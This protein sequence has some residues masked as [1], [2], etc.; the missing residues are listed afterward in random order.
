[1]ADKQIH[2]AASNILSNKVSAILILGLDLIYIFS[3][4]YTKLIRFMPLLVL[5]VDLS[6]LASPTAENF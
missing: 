3:Y 5:C 2:P 4:K 6:V 1:N